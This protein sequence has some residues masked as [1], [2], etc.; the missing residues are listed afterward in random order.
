MK[1]SRV[2]T[3]YA[4]ASPFRAGLARLREL[5]LQT[6]LSE[7]YKWSAPIYTLDNKNVFG[8]TAFKSHFGIWFFN[9]CYLKDPKKVLENA[10]EGKTRA[11]RHWKFTAADEIDTELVLSYMKEAVENQKEGLVWTPEKKKR[12]RIPL[13]LEEILKADEDLLD[14]FGKLPP[15][16]QSEFCELIASAKRAST[17]RKRLEEIIPLIRQGIGINDKYRK[18]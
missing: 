6:G 8:I 12:T 3:F 7:T 10:Q 9:G 15:Y 14:A 16:K 2:E 1:G 4:K 5:A 18:T 11:M 17:K 13:E